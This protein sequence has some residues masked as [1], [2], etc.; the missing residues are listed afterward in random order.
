LTIFKTSL[1]DIAISKS[2]QVCGLL[3]GK[4]EQCAKTADSMPSGMK[5][6]RL[7]CHKGATGIIFGAGAPNQR[8]ALIMRT[9]PVRGKTRYILQRDIN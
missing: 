3:V 6:G 7:L 8:E 2:P 4:G 5:K 9:E 1:A